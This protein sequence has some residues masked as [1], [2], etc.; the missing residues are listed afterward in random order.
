M[1]E[2]ETKIVPFEKKILLNGAEGTVYTG[3]G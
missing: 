1:G 2:K 3:A